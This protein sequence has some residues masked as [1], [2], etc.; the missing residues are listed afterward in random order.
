MTYEELMELRDLA[1]RLRALDCEHPDIT[2]LGHDLAR[3]IEYHLDHGVPPA[4]KP[5][6]SAMPRFFLATAL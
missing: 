4:P 1:A 6:S 5:A 3:R 2:I